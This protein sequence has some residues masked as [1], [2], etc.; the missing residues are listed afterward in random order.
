MSTMLQLPDETR[1]GSYFV[2]NYPPYSQWSPDQVPEFEAALAEPSA[3]GPLGLYVHIPFCRQRCSYCYFRIHVR[4]SQ[5]EVERYI[6][7]VIN[8]AAVYAAVPAVAGRPLANVYLGGGTPTHL[9]TPQI[10]R[11]FGTL[12]RLFDWTAADEVT[13]ECQ[14][15]TCEQDK[16]AALKRM[17]VTRASIGV[18]TFTDAVLRGV[19]RAAGVADCLHI[20]DLA[21][22]TRFEQVNIDLMAGLPGETEQSWHQT[23]ERTASL[24]PDCVTIYQFELTHNSLLNKAIQA[25]RQVDLPSW[26]E[27]RRWVRHAFDYLSARGY[28]VYG[29]YWAVRDPARHRFAYVTDHYWRGHDLLALGESSFGSLH[30]FHYQ[31]VDTYDAYTAACSDHR[32]PLGRAYRMN[33][34]ERLR[35][36]FILQLKTGRV[37]IKQLQELFAVDV[38]S[39]LAEPLNMLRDNGMLTWD[40]QSVQ[41]TSEGLL[42]VDWL[43]PQF[44]LPQ[45]VGIRYT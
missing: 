9:T 25:G 37:N 16:L 39:R 23:I 4:R 31:N 14:P 18:Q 44:Y 30:H 21:R 40:A 11:L 27:K 41:L 10:E 34:E 5:P 22:R 2:S 28:A 1:V 36:Q 6:D 32:L 12:R 42:C 8:E 13:C 3:P 7:A 20:F 17:G 35:R 24:G 33:D 19:G 43:L 45:H 38:A 15:G 29:A 26:P